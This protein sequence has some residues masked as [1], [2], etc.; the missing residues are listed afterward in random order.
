M[1]VPPSPVVGMVFGVG[2]GF[3]VGVFVGG[4]TLGDAAVAVA[5]G[6]ALV[7][8]GVGVGVLTGGGVFVGAVVAVGAATVAVGAGTVG[9]GGG[10]GGVMGVGINV[11]GGGGVLAAA[12]PCDVERWVADPTASRP[13]VRGIAIPMVMRLFIIQ[14]SLRV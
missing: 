7:G 11:G 4:V 12:K 2:I 10:G 14:D 13:A 9:D 1:N 5:C 3:G 6:A 8:L